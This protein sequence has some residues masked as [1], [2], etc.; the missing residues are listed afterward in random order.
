MTL[1]HQVRDPGIRGLISPIHLI[2][3]REKKT[4]QIILYLVVQHALQAVVKTM[5]LGG[6][7]RMTAPNST[8]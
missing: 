2:C 5:K 6:A 4:V 7:T 8:F 3:P 1:S